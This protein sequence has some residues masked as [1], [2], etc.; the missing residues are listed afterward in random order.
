MKKAIILTWDKFQDDEVIYPYYRLQEAGFKVDVFGEKFGPMHGIQG[1]KLNATISFEHF[2]R[3]AIPDL[4]AMYDFVCI[5]GGVKALE[6]LRQQKFVLDFITAFNA[7]GKTIASICHGA[8]MLISA[9]I[10]NGRDVLGY[11]S[12][13]DDIENAGAR[14]P[15]SPVAVSKNLITAAHYDYMPEW[16]I[17]A[18]NVYD[19]W[20]EKN[21]HVL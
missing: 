8:Q 18:L 10:C 3:M 1:V 11:Y 15:N 5:P 12:I 21:R 16:M 19:A 7:E 6:K 20:Y 2:Y 14:Y 17:T 9:K 4:V 13:R